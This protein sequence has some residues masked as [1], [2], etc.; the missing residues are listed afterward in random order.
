MTIETLTGIAA[1]IAT[2]EPV[3]AFGEG[4]A[5]RVASLSWPRFCLDIVQLPAQHGIDACIDVVVQTG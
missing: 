2:T 3:P 1:T 5:V 4:A